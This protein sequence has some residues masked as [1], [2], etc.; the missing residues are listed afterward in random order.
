MLTSASGSRRLLFCT[1]PYMMSAQF[2]PKFGI[3]LKN[4]TVYFSQRQVALS[5]E[6]ISLLLFQQP[7]P[8]KKPK[9]CDVIQYQQEDWNAIFWYTSNGRILPRQLVPVS[10]NPYPG[11]KAVGRFPPSH[12]PE[13]VNRDHTSPLIATQ[14]GN[15]LPCM[16]LSKTP[17]NNPLN[18]KEALQP[19]QLSIH[20][21]RRNS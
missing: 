20:A 6:N 8:R 16:P 3:D 18:L 7:V 12:V 14:G 1:S 4:S 2:T 17:P 15:N 11:R 5:R 13:S 9:R 10:G 21:R 19:W